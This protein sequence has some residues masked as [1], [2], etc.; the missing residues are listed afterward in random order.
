MSGSGAFRTASDSL[1]EVRV[2]AE[3]YGGAHTADAA[4][5]AV[6]APAPG[7]MHEAAS[8]VAREA[9]ATGAGVLEVVTRRGRLGPG[10]PRALMAAAG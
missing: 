2:P 4:V 10:T 7:I 8:A 1:G 9:L 3:A 5:G 6:T